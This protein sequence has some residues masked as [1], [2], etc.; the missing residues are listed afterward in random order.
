MLGNYYL[1]VHST[2]TMGKAIKIV[3]GSFL[4]VLFIF[5]VITPFVE[6]KRKV[7]RSVDINV[8]SEKVFEQ[9]NVPRNWLNW[10]SA[11]SRCPDTKFYYSGN[12]E[13]RDA[14]LSAES[15]TCG[16]VSYQITK[17]T[18]NEIVA[19]DINIENSGMLGKGSITIDPAPSGGVRVDFINIWDLGDVPFYKRLFAVMMF[20]SMV[21]GDLEHKAQGLKAFCE[22]ATH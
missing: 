11:D 17:S 21:G 22:S 1:A 13:G 14:K 5:A 2:E 19:F 12:V 15:K 20:D 9:I 7:V 18:V 6:T 10:T 3:L 8:P 4:A 16:N